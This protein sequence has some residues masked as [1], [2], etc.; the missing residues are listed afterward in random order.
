MQRIEA[1]LLYGAL[2]YCNNCT[3]VTSLKCFTAW[4]YQFA[5]IKQA[6]PHGGEKLC[7]C[8]S[9]LHTCFLMDRTSKG[10]NVRQAT[11]CRA[12]AS[13]FLVC[14]SYLHFDRVLSFGLWNLWNL[15]TKW[16][17]TWIP[18][19][20]S[21][22]ISTKRPLEVW[23][24]GDANQL[25]LNAVNSEASVADLEGLR[26]SQIP[27]HWC[28]RNMYR[29]LPSVN[30]HAKI[31]V[32]NREKEG[33]TRWTRCTT[34]RTRTPWVKD[35]LRCFGFVGMPRPFCCKSCISHP[36]RCWSFH[37]PLQLTQWDFLRH[38]D[39]IKLD[40]ASE[41]NPRNEEATPNK[42]SVHMQWNFQFWATSTL[43]C[44]KISNRSLDWYARMMILIAV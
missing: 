4:R 15:L 18:P 42:L 29:L 19:G 28:L 10:R 17:L 31:V 5:L 37:M 23:A 24:L 1:G 21:N 20:K 12:S 2:V 11:F 36:H 26:Q 22:W 30:K 33:W 8:V 39:V 25:W 44:R 38:L 7:K 6:K 34:S 9:L 13:L 40:W 32:I 3:G 16:L 43:Q 14:I 41:S 27:V 35:W